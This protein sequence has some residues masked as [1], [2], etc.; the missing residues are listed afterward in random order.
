M[1]GLTSGLTTP[2]LLEELESLD[3]STLDLI[4]EKGKNNL[5]FMCKGILGMRD[6][7]PRLHGPMTNHIQ[8]EP[9]KRR[10]T[11]A[12]RG[13]LK[14]SVGLEGDC[15]R[16]GVKDPEV[17]CLIVNWKDENASDMFKAIRD[18]FERNE[19]LRFLYADVIPESFV[20]PGVTWSS[21]GATLVRK[22]IYREPTYMAAGLTTEVASKHFTHIKC[23]DIFALEAAKSNIKM[24]IPQRWIRSIDGLTIGYTRTQIDFIG[25]RWGSNDIYRFIQD[26]MGDDLAV[27]VRSFEDHEGELYM[28]DRYP[29]YFFENMKEKNPE[30]YWSQWVNDPEAAELADFHPQ[31]LRQYDWKKD[32]TIEYAD[33]DELYEVHW[34]ELDRVV[35]ADP[36]SGR[37][38]APDEAAV[39]AVGQ[40][41]REKQF[42]LAEHA[43]RFSPSG[44]VEAIFDMCVRWRPRVVGIEEAGQQNTLFYFQEHC[45]KKGVHFN[46]EPLKPDNNKSKEERIRK[47]FEPIIHAGRYYVLPR[48][49]K[50]KTQVLQ[51]PWGKLVDVIDSAAYAQR[52]LRKP[53]SDE[54]YEESEDMAHKML[55]RRHVRTGY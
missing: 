31:G 16:L 1:E 32:G 48:H 24:E 23:D 13:H 37:K 5:Y 54:Q 11:L 46:V 25:T 20:G 53:W 42:H 40:D 6:L 14:T 38:T 28:G 55:N 41:W 15:V 30:E 8:H 50:I 33:N 19:L 52:L 44:F 7:V 47:L 10:L 35:V 17:R 26:Q 21:S 3:T 27:F 49:T 9:K 45:K 4:R 2:E 36:N 12:S 22:G 39:I 29:R 34:S 43:D 18:H 51:F